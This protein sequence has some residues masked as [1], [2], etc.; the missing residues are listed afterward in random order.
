MVEGKGE[1]VATAAPDD[2]EDE[3]SSTYFA[4][5]LTAIGEQLAIRYDN[6]TGLT[7]NQNRILLEIS[8]EDGLT[9]TEL[10]HRLDMHKVSVGL[11][12]AELE[13]MN[14]VMRE[15]HPTDGRAKCLRI[16]PFLMAQA[17]RAREAFS[18]IHSVATEGISRKDYLTMLDCL[19]RM[20]ANLTRMSEME[21]EMVVAHESGA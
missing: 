20:H 6:A 9:Q 4:Q 8:Q 19:A 3:L 16:T 15:A 1:N 2:T 21:S 12:I 13:A 5:L 10:A 17:P 14:L 7:R 11:H 18:R